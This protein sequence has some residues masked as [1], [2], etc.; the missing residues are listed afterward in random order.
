[1]SNNN[2][3]SGLELAFKFF[4]L[5]YVFLITCG[6]TYNYFFYKNF[7]ITITEY[8]NLTDGLL[9][10]IPL[11]ANGS[12]IL[13]VFIVLWHLMNRAFLFNINIGP[14]KASEQRELRKQMLYIF[15]TSLILIL[16]TFFLCVFKV[17]N[18]RTFY[19]L[20]LV[21][22]VLFLPSILEMIF[23]FFQNEWPLNSSNGLRDIFYLLIVF[24]GLVVY[25]SY[26]KTEKIFRTRAYTPFEIYFNNTDS[27]LKSDSNTYYLGR[28]S[29]YIF[30]Y[31][32]KKDQ[33]KVLN[34]SDVKTFIC[35]GRK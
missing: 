25:A 15:Y 6:L 20:I 11:L 33:T 30:I 27:S 23:S 35:T 2:K 7:G 17:L 1:M 8:I 9:L 3:L 18:Y 32:F 12:I 24:I 34:V 26:S 13:C 21:T 19:M 22:V 29:N 14:R 4:S 5:A 10:F 28:T 16:I 31:D